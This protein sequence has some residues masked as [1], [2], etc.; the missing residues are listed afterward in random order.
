MVSNERSRNSITGGEGFR[1]W[2]YE[3]AHDSHL[4]RG[5]H[6]HGGWKPAFI[7]IAYAV[8]EAPLF[9]GCSGDCGVVWTIAVLGSK[10]NAEN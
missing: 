4:W 1:E 3:E 2:A 8:L 10:A 6:E 5:E 9:H 7:L